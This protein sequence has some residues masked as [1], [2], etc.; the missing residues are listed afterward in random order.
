M[1]QKATKLRFE[2]SVDATSDQDEANYDSRGGLKRSD[3][4]ERLDGEIPRAESEIDGQST[5]D[6]E[7]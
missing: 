5:E 3:C 7:H 2:E 4:M 1:N 6:G